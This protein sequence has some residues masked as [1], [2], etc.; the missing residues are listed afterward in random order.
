MSHRR[1]PQL[2]PWESI[3]LLL[4]CL[5]LGG[6]IAAILLSQPSAAQ[7]RSGPPLPNKPQLGSLGE[8]VN[9]N[10]IAMSSWVCA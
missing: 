10:T 2:R 1:G 8:R 4:A 9:S 6:L 3:C 5:F 7:N